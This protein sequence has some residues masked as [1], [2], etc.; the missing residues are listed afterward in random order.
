M[1][2]KFCF[3]HYLMLNIVYFLPFYSVENYQKKKLTFLLHIV[4]DNLIHG[5]EYQIALFEIFSQTSP[6]E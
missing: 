6:K 2:N 4:S 3:K 1:K 5:K